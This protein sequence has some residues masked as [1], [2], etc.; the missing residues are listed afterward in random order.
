MFGYLQPDLASISEKDVKLLHMYNCSI[1]KQFARNGTKFCLYQNFDFGFLNAFLHI[2]FNKKN[3]HS[4]NLC[5]FSVFSKSEFIDDDLSKK[6]MEIATIL[7]HFQA[8]SSR[9][10]S[11]KKL[12]KIIKEVN[13]KSFKKVFSTNEKLCL[14]I[15]KELNN[16]YINKQN[17]TV[18]L[19]EYCQPIGKVLERISQEF[20]EDK[21]VQV[22]FF[23]VGCWICLADVICNL[24]F[25]HQHKYYNPLFTKH[26]YQGNKENFLHFFNK[27]IGGIYYY[28]LNNIKKQ[29]YQ[30]KNINKSS[31]IKN[32]LLDAP[33]N[34]GQQYLK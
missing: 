26:N 16:F 25:D 8:I 32:V 18:D 14:D 7:F 6:V 12:G 31:L 22:L 13:A 34:F 19:R 17:S 4:K 1:C 24:N 3:T 30:I 2:Y 21:K 10:I 27:E 28:F 33:F 23:Y 20:V 5:V 9:K 11:D 29:Y 15:A